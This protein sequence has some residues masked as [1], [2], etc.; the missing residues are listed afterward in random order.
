MGFHRSP[1]RL[2]ASREWLR[3]VERNA[4]TIAAAGLPS[5]VMANI[6]DWD[7][8]LVRGSLTHDPTGFTID[9]LTSDQYAALVGLVESYFAAGYEFFAPSALRSDDQERLRARFEG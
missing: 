2:A 7:D 4:Q 3:F 1:D 9:Q 8:V 5:T 6:T